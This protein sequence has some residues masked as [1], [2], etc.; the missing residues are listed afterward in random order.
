MEKMVKEG[1]LGHPERRKSITSTNMSTYNTLY[2]PQ[3]CKFIC[4][5]WSKNYAIWYSK[6]WYFKVGKVK[7][8]EWK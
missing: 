2:Y 5:D 1:I 7:G 3:V 6:Q 8:P 4:D